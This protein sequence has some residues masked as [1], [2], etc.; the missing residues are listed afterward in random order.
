MI[1]MALGCEQIP[2]L[3]VKTLAEHFARLAQSAIVDLLINLRF[4]NVLMSTRDP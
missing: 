4:L 1:F 2:R 3:F